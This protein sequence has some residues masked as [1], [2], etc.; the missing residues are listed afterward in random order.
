[1]AVPRCHSPAGL[2]GSLQHPLEGSMKKLTYALFA[3]FVVALASAGVALAGEPDQPQN[4]GDPDAGQ[5][6]WMNLDNERRADNGEI[7][8]RCATEERG[9]PASAPEKALIDQW[10]QENRIAAGGV[11]PVNVHIIMGR[12]G[13]GNVTDAQVAAQI[14]VLNRNFAGKDYNGN[15]VPGAANTGYT[16]VLASTNRVTNRKWFGMTPGSGAE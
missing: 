5:G 6:R 12:G 3:V 10:I 1:M 9:R 7:I 4:M 8:Y 15:T 14:T 11:I 13:A 16:F 2:I